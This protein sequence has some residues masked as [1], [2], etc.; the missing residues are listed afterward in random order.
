MTTKKST[1]CISAILWVHNLKI[2]QKKLRLSRD[3]GNCPP[4]GDKI[5]KK[6]TI[7][8]SKKG[9]KIEKGREHSEKLTNFPKKRAYIFKN[10]RRRK[11][12]LLKNFAPAP[13]P[14]ILGMSLDWAFIINVLYHNFPILI[15]KK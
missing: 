4:I 13:H 2:V 3:G 8:G 9:R 15:K 7:R 12:I 10:V 14:E 5:K 1:F 11:K 6:F